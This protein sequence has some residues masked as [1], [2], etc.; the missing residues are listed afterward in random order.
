MA[1]RLVESFG[2]AIYSLQSRTRKRH[3]DIIHRSPQWAPGLAEMA[4]Q[5]GI[6]AITSKASLC[7]PFATPCQPSLN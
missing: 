3:T 2:K 7:S 6:L 4:R 5:N 1:P